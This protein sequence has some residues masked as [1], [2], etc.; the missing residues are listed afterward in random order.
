MRRCVL[1]LPLL[2]IS[3][4]GCVSTVATVVTAPVRVAGWTAD[5]LTTSQAEADRNYG[6]KMRKRE[7]R[8]GKEERRAAKERER[9]ERDNGYGG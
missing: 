1:L 5:K 6:R 3:L 8:E 2:G 7:E 9:A 4:G